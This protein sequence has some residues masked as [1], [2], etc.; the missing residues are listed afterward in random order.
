MKGVGEIYDR[1]VHGQGRHVRR[2]RRRLHLQRDRLPAAQRVLPLLGLASSRR[3]PSGP[4]GEIYIALRRP[5]P[6]T[7]RGDDGD[8]YLVSST[9][10]GQTWTRPTRLNDDDTA[11]RS[12]SSRPSTWRPD[13]T[14]HVMW[15]DMRDD[16]AQ[17][18]YHI[19]YTALRRTAAR[20]GASRTRTWTS[21]PATPGSPTSPP[22]PT[23]ASPAACSSATTSPSR[24]PTTTSTWSG[25]TPASASTARRTRRSASRASRPSRRRSSSCH[26]R[27]AR[28]ASR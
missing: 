26:R 22:T 7:D 5:S 15:G 9:D 20:P 3:S 2:A 18:R 17:T 16:P 14:V 19:Y 25:P 10:E 6:R 4:T 8:I 23:A 24:R 13:G 27:P 1:P 12:S 21:A 11:R 28:A